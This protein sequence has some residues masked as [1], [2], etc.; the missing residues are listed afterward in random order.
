[1]AF[2]HRRGAICGDGGSAVGA[3][4]GDQDL[5]L[6][7]GCVFLATFGGT[8]TANAYRSASFRTHDEDY[9]YVTMEA[10]LAR[11]PHQ[12]H[13]LGGGP[14]EF[15]ITTERLVVEPRPSVAAAIDGLCDQARPAALG[16]RDI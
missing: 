1:M 10:M 4:R 12:L 15:V 6:Q 2:V 14:L 5:G 11:N 16:Q 3:V 9:G 13:G 7:I 8:N